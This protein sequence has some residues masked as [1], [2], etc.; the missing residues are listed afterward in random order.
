[1]R[2][3]FFSFFL[4]IGVGAVFYFSWIPQPDFRK[5]SFIPDWLANWSN[6]HDTLRTGIP[7]IFLGLYSGLWLIYSN[8]SLI[9]W[10]FAWFAFVLIVVVAE[11]GQLFLPQRV[12]DWRDII[13]GC[14]G[15]LCGLLTAAI[16][17]RLI[18][19]ISRFFFI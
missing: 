4:I 19:T 12:F 9:R 7:F 14:A 16:F 11:S 13:W 2:T 5:L 8:G 6:T 15:A 1:M 18:K 17:Y 3:I 10:L